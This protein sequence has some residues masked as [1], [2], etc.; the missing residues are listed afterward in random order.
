MNILSTKTKGYIAITTV[1]LIS[2]VTLMIAVTVTLVSINEGQS[3]LASSKGEERLSFVDGCME[4][5]ILKIRNSASYAGGTTT[6]PDGNCSITVSKV[7]SVYT[8]TASPADLTFMKKLQA[9]VTRGA[10]TVT[11]TSWQEI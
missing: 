10:S 8:V 5:A 1:L 9:V 7:G 3:S 6:T 4:D 11:I 2:A